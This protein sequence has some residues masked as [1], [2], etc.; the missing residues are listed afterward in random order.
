[1]TWEPETFLKR[2][3]ENSNFSSLFAIFSSLFLGVWEKQKHPEKRK[4][5]YMFLLTYISSLISAHF[6][7]HAPFWCHTSH[8]KPL[9]VNGIGSQRE[10]LKKKTPE[11][12]TKHVCWNTSARWSQHTFVSTRHSGAIRHSHLWYRTQRAGESWKYCGSDSR[13]CTVRGARESTCLE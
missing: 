5:K 7:E 10:S 12:K 2:D 3:L 4:P 13:H 1:V 9:F 11:E 6:D 8:W